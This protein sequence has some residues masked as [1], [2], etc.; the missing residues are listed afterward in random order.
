MKDRIF[1]AQ[2]GVS[3]LKTNDVSDDL[4]EVSGVIKW[5]DVAKGYGF[6]IPDKDL[7][8]VDDRGDVL[9]HASVLQRSGFQS[10]L[11]GAHIFCVAKQGANGLQAIHV[12]SLDLS[13]ATPPVQ[14]Q[15]KRHE[16]IV[17]TSGLER[18]LVKWF[19]RT[20]GFGFLSRGSG[21]E[22]IFI[23]MEV[24]RRYGLT[25][26]NPGQVVLVRFGSSD[27]GLMAVEIYPDNPL[28]FTSSSLMN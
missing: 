1:S 20:K 7:I 22:D 14:T 17:P 5:F 4:V 27:H 8:N 23:H 15:P 24:L 18:A 19:N 12:H 3:P 13:M 28:S 6:I 2:T 11:E 26:L 10:A 9:L 21:T 25:E 16:N